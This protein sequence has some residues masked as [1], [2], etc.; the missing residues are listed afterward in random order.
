MSCP[1]DC[2]CYVEGL[3]GIRSDGVGSA[4]DPYTPQ[5]DDDYTIPVTVTTYANMPGATADD[6]GWRAFVQDEHIFYVWNGTFWEVEG[7][8]WAQ[9]YPADALITSGQAVWQAF[10][11]TLT[12]PAGAWFI[13]GNG[14]FEGSIDP[15]TNASSTWPA[16]GVTEIWTQKMY[17]RIRNVTDNVV[18]DTAPWETP[19][20]IAWLSS[21]SADSISVGFPFKTPFQLQNALVVDHEIEVQ[22]EASVGEVADPFVLAGEYNVTHLDLFAQTLAYHDFTT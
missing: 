10:T 12:L 22:F 20:R 19:P 6:T 4:I 3:R 9:T 5:P 2:N 16:P 1:D 18:L 13:C 17:G 8:R 14:A 7:A 21:D 11:P 15:D